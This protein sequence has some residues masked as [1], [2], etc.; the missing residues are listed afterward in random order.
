MS[1]LELRGIPTVFIATVEFTD[2]ADRQAEALGVDLA[3]VFVEHPIQD[4]TDEEMVEIANQAFDEI[5][6]KLVG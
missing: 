1:E 5:V 6:A 4:R 3:R 2:G